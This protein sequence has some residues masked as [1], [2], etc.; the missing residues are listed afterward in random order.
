MADHD[1]G[2]H[3]P[4][5]DFFGATAHVDPP[6]TAPGAATP[7]SQ[8]QSNR[9]GTT[10][11][12]ADTGGGLVPAGAPA[13]IDTR[14]SRMSTGTKVLVGVVCAIAVL[15][16]VA[17]LAAIAIP[18]F[19]NQRAKATAAATTLTLPPSI[20]SRQQ[21]TDS[22]SL[23][24]AE[25][26]RAGL[27][28]GTKVALYG[29][30]GD[31]SLIVYVYPSFLPAGADAAFVAGI[32]QSSAG[33]GSPMHK[34]EPGSLGGQGRCGELGAGGATHC[35]FADAAGAVGVMVRSTGAPA[36]REAVSIR[37]QVE[38]RRN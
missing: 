30:P 25:Q 18:V 10:V 32:A 9:F 34:A 6:A 36:E 19:L 35:V 37:E 1:Q 21:L 13:A 20:G 4:G 3:S 2:R 27:P 22:A 7:P 12:V 23:S 38:Q 29:S 16:M 15:V 17:V 8:Q 33:E 28:T 5:Y 26:I 31:A 14:R 11:P 24:A